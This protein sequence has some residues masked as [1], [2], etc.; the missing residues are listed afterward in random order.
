M[1]CPA[2]T[3][4]GMARVGRDD[5]GRP[6]GAQT[7]RADRPVRPG[8]DHASAGLCGDRPVCGSA[9]AARQ[10]QPYRHHGDHI[11]GLGPDAVAGDRIRDQGV[12]RPRRPRSDHVVAGPADQRV[13]GPYR[14]DRAVGQCDGIAAVDAVRGRSRDRRRRQMVRSLRRRGRDRPVGHGGCDRGHDP[15]VS[16]DRPE[17]DAAGGADSRGDHRRRFCHRAAGRRDP[18]LWHLVAVRGSDLGRCRR[19]CARR[20]Q[21][22]SGGRRARRLAMARRCCSCSPAGCFCSAS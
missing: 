13:F 3:Q 17:P 8:R 11:P 16:S 2:R 22:R 12:L 15:A 14:R 9:A 7:R 21:H 20:R 19:L 6:Q 18:V 4:A 5:D 1:V 10:I